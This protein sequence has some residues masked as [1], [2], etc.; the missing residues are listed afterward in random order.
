MVAIHGVV[1]AAIF[2]AAVVTS[3]LR[4]PQPPRQRTQIAQPVV[5]VA[6]GPVV[7]PR[8]ARTSPYPVPT[9][10]HAPSGRAVLLGAPN[11]P[12]RWLGPDASTVDRYRAET[13]RNWWADFGA[14]R[15]RATFP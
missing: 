6:A 11:A 15:P 1:L 4:A 3:T 13:G 7:I 5:D 12:H 14:P 10:R 2:S 9:G 8:L